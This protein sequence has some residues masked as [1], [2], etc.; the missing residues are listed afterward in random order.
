MIKKKQKRLKK[1]L[2]LFDVFAIAT[3]ATVSGGFFLLPG[4]AAQSL[5]AEIFLA[6]LLAALPLLP[7]MFSKIELATALPRSGGVYFFLDRTLGPA[8]GAI[9]GLGIWITLNLKVAFALIG[10]GAYLKIFFPEIQ[11]VYVAIFI[12]IL[13]CLLNLG[14]AKKSGTLQIILVIVLLIILSVFLVG[15]L[16]EIN[17]GNFSTIKDLKFDD[18]FATTGLVFMS[19]LGVTKVAS[20]SEEIHN[21]E[22]NIPH[23]VFWGMGTAL[24]IYTIGT[25]IMAGV[26]P[27]DKLTG[28]LTPVADTAEIIFGQWGKVLLTIAALLAFISVSNVGILS[29][30]RY[31]LAMSRDHL[32]PRIFM[33][34]NKKGSPANSILIT[35]LVIIL[36]IVF[37]DPIKIAKLAS[38]FQL[39]IFS[40]LSLAVIVMRESKLDSYDPGYKSPFY[41]WT[42]IFGI[43]I[44]IL[45]II[46]MGLLP[47]LFSIGL[48]TISAIWYAYYAKD[49]VE[50]NGAIY[51]LFERLGKQ[52]YDGLDSELRGILKE[53][54]LRE[55]D[56]FDEI[57]AR[58]YVIDLPEKDSF[59]NVVIIAS[60]WISQFVEKTSADIEQMFLEGTRMGATP[61]THGI[62]LPH[63]RLKGLSQAE[64][65]IVRAQK[66]IHIKFKD[67]LTDAE[68]EEQD[69]HVVFFL[70]SPENDPTQHL[71]ILAQIAGRVEEDGFEEEWKTASDEQEIKEAIIHED[72][73]LSLTIDQ[74]TKTAELV[75]KALKEIR[76]PEGCLVAMLRRKGVTIIPKGKTVLES[77]DRLT[78]IGNPKG[79]AELKQ[80]FEEP[81]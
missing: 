73:C 57:V 3:G 35:T 70:V 80:R 60:S 76:F 30:S 65:V 17:L 36:M 47:I 31:P 14:G 11:L 61:V 45:L 40:A 42:Q 41:P 69:V 72:R 75:G 29:S 4:L 33:K 56:P 78:I 8:M 27:L 49:K 53:K 9:G 16:P 23:G 67:P 54:G 58:S 59:E 63:L 64:M 38:A 26:M 13:L 6:Y 50:R 55:S 21:P 18:L 68:N 71:R 66:G 5:G 32:V 10:M 7:A 12:A 81:H 37:L 46:S 44:S 77:G 43:V 62:A 79:M 52:R 1:E 19:Y 25:F 20:V 51:H 39:L 15:G 24:V 28:S 2:K 48:I 22:K 34:F 74:K